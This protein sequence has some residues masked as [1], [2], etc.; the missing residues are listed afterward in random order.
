GSATPHPSVLA[1]TVASARMGLRQTWLPACAGTNGR[2]KARTRTVALI[3]HPRL[4]R[5]LDVV[6]LVELHVDE[7]A[8]ALFH[9]PDVD[10]LHHVARLRINRHRPAR[11]FPA[12]AL[13]GCG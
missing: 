1:Q 5:V 11:A 13:G 4:E 2:S 10:R 3:L 12:H 7:R 9:P 8:V 6:D